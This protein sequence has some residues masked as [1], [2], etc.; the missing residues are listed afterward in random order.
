[1]LAIAVVVIFECVLIDFEWFVFFTSK[2]CSLQSGARLHWNCNCCCVVEYVIR[3][4]M[5]KLIH[6]VQ[7]LVA[8]SEKG[9]LLE[10]VRTGHCTLQL[11]AL[12]HARRSKNKRFRH[13]S[14][15][16]FHL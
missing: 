7:L 5:Y 13:S 9:R 12:K 15:I 8:A 2:C 14:I 3:S 1:M 4:S 10:N 6:I 11:V 16:S